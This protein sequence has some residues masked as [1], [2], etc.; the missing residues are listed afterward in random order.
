MIPPLGCANFDTGCRCSDCCDREIWLIAKNSKVPPGPPAPSPFHPATMKGWAI[1]EPAFW[2][3]PPAP[4]PPLKDE[5]LLPMNCVWC[6]H[7]NEFV[8]K[9][10]LIN[11]EYVCRQCRPRLGLRVVDG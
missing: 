7:R 8:G 5:K 3:T 11:G 1:D 6:Q 2:T 4:S 10:H 9:E